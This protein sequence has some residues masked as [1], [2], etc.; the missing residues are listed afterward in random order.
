MRKIRESNE[1]AI[2][3]KLKDGDTTV[4]AFQAIVS[5]TTDKDNYFYLK[6]VAEKMD[7]YHV[8][9]VIRYFK[10]YDNIMR[11]YACWMV[12][13]S[14]IP[15]DDK[16]FTKCYETAKAFASGRI[17]EQ[18]M[19]MAC[20][21]AWDHKTDNYS[22]YDAKQAMHWT[23]SRDITG[24]MDGISMNCSYAYTRNEYDEVKRMALWNESKENQRSE[25]IRIC[26][27]V[28]NK[29]SPY[30]ELIHIEQLGFQRDYK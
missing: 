29:I 28:E 7:M 11:L 6:D 2:R 19:R 17:H 23:A 22:N 12:E 13:Q 20:D 21:A 24:I 16:V 5:V 10:G 27:C 3:A 14:P 4:A 1:N 25:L 15:T 26:E 8:M 9:M 30:P 18:E